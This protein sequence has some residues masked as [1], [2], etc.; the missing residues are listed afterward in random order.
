MKAA[1]LSHIC[2]DSAIDEFDALE[3]I[4]DA[5][6]RYADKVFTARDHDNWTQADCLITDAR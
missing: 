1:R 4:V 3:R 6:Q 2:V 5:G